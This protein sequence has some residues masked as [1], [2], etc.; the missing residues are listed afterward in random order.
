MLSEDFMYWLESWPDQ[1]SPQEATVAWLDQ[2]P[3]GRAITG[4][5]RELARREKGKLKWRV[6]EANGD[7][8]SPQKW[9]PLG[10]FSSR[11]LCL[12]WES[13]SP[14]QDLQCLQPAFTAEEL[15]QVVYMALYQGHAGLHSPSGE[16]AQGEPPQDYMESPEGFTQVPMEM[17]FGFDKDRGLVVCGFSQKTSTLG[18]DAAAADRIA[19]KLIETAALLRAA[20]H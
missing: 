4:P 8:N 9:Q 2:C 15:R 12:R 13:R 11:G 1:P 14:D 10:G 5:N 20:S 3:I 6:Y 18:L 16:P 19:A 7:P 17:S